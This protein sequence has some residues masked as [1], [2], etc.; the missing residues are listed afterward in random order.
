MS[1]NLALVETCR[2]ITGYIKET[3][4]S[5][6]SA[7]LPEPDE[8]AHRAIVE[9]IASRDPERAAAAVRELMAPTLNALALGTA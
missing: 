5:T 1:G 2:F 9:G 4:A 7:S 3:I 8:A 6:L